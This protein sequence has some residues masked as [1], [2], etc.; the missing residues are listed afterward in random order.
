VNVT[1]PVISFTFAFIR[2]VVIVAVPIAS[3]T[4]KVGGFAQLLL[5]DNDV[6]CGRAEP[7]V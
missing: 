3:L 4:Q 2:A 5:I 6:F 7:V 1:T